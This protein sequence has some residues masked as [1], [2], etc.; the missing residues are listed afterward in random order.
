MWLKQYFL[1]RLQS[2][3]SSSLLPEVFL[4]YKDLFA[5]ACSLVGTPSSSMLPGPQPPFID[6]AEAQG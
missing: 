2:H 4:G 1:V 3:F 6:F 5:L